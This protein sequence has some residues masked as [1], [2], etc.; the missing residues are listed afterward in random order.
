MRSTVND[1]SQC[2]VAGAGT[3]SSNS[4]FDSAPVN[5]R[6]VVDGMNPPIEIV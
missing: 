1:V 2:A 6:A 4:V 3:R 5:I